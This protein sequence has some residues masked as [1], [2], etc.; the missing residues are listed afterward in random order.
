MGQF[1]TLRRPGGAGG[2]DQGGQVV[3]AYRLP[4]GVEIEILGGIAFDP[5]EGG[6]AC[7][8]GTIDDYHLLELYS[9]RGD[10]GKKGLFGDDH[11]IAGVAEDMRDLV[12]GAGVVHRERGGAQVQDRGVDEIELRPV[13]EHDANRVTVSDTEFRQS[14]RDGVHPPCIVGPGDLQVSA[15]SA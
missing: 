2:I 14:C 5:I 11:G 15:D 3:G 4:G 6:S 13:G 10:R 9:G 8:C 1:H 7:G 12:G